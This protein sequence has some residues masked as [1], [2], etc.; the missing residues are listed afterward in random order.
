LNNKETQELPLRRTVLVGLLTGLL[1]NITGW[2]GNN[3]ILGSM[4]DE[5]G[6]SLIPV[7]WRQSIWSDLF[8]LVPDFVY[9]VAIS[10]LIA[11]LRNAHESILATSIKV[12]ILISL[13]G[14]ITTY[15][16]LANSGFVPWTLALA[17][18]VLVLVCKVP[19]AILAGR[20]LSKK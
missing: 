11:R 1:L 10:W 20:L 9:G 6:A 3:F 19:L 15:F 16:A 7:P 18:F 13:V 17:S 12:G 5:L 14:G 8:S 4:W 2:L